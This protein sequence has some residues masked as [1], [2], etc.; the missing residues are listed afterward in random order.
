MRCLFRR[1][2]STTTQT[3]SRSIANV[4]E[5]RSLGWNAFR[6]SAE[7][8]SKCHGVASRGA[9]CV[10]V[11]VDALSR[12]LYWAGPGLPCS[13]IIP[14]YN[15]IRSSGPARSWSARPQRG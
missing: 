8:V 4:V 10:C 9:G 6:S 15:S 3:Q 2:A 7:S 12:G 13:S 14:V 5:A 11:G 1:L